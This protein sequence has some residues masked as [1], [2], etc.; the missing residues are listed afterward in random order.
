MSK[1]KIF[2][3]ANPVVGIKEYYSIHDFF[4]S[5]DPASLDPSHFQSLSDEQI[6][7]SIWILDGVSWLKITENN[8]TGKTV[9]YTFSQ[10]SLNRKGIRMLVDANGEKAVLDITTQKT[11]QSKIIKIDLLDSN[12][13]KRTPDKP[14]AYGDWI[15]ARVH[16]VAMER[17]PIT[18][19]LWEDDGDKAKQDT[20]N[21]KIEVKKG[22]VLNGTAEVSFY[23][24][25]SHVWLANAKLAPGDKN[26]GAT[27]EY[28]VTAEFLEK[29]P[30]RVA[31][32]NTNVPNPDYKPEI[33]KPKPQIPASNK[34]PSKKEQ[35]GI[36]K[37]EQ[38]VHDYHEQKVTVQNKV[39]FNHMD[40]INSLMTVSVDPDWWKTKEEK[41]HQICE[42][43]ARVKAFLRMLRVGEGTDSERGYTTQFS[44]KQFSNMSN[45][46]HEIISAN[47]YFSSAAGAYQIMSD[48]YDG[49]ETYRTKYN[50]L[51]FNQ[52]SQDRLCIV[53]LKHNYTTD[54]PN[55]FY[56]PI[57]WKNKD[58]TI[59]DVEK[60][61]KI[62][63]RRKKFKGQQADIIKLII[64]NDIKKATLLSSLCWA[65]LPD[66]PYGQPTKTIQEC[67]ANYEK[68]LKEELTNQQTWK[69]HLKEGFLKEFGYSCCAEQ[70]EFQS[71]SC[72]KCNENHYDVA[73]TEHWITQKPHECWAASV[74]ILKNYGI[75][76][77]T[78]I[79][80]IY[81]VD[82]KGNKLN[83][84]NAQAGLDYIDSQLKLGKP[85]IVGLDDNLRKST[86]NTHKATDHFF[87]IVG[88]GCEDGNIYYRFFDVGSKI[89]EEGTAEKN[90]LYLQDN[91]MLVGKSY[92]NTHNYTVTEVRRNN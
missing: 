51:N 24:N 54:R 2:G 84:Q 12:Y 11:S 13:D 17:Y 41:K 87:V 32:M 20:T 61:T 66:S 65:S 34:E 45:H 22:N 48:T 3:K 83:V 50:I 88:K 42:Y 19:T 77:G 63:D 23:L 79:N 85:V 29:I 5:S 69:L 86:Y 49:L 38:K 80:P 74:K 92:G 70:T 39:V 7:W 76:G 37:S 89:S 28:Y 64:D 46:P 27:H 18:V 72:D 71:G 58:K 52:E 60:E 44:G 81:T 75:I 90:K 25:P 6:K 16:C 68:F 10:K 1:L 14:F 9:H 73:K 8:K 91:L 15:I 35:K 31:S 59:R 67:K 56:N 21:V 78:N 33:E 36:N 82:Q 26:E 47:G 55:S 4:G 62:K 53:I 57:Y 43:E 40:P 30:K